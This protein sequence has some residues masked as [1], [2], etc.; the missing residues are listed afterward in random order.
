LPGD[1]RSMRLRWFGRRI[2]RKSGARVRRIAASRSEI[3]SWLVKRLAETLALSEEDV[4]VS[5]PFDRYGLD[6]R[7]AASLSAELEDWLERALPATLVWDY[8]TIASVA[9]FLGAVDGSVSGVGRESCG[10]P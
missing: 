8:P 7:T 4:D 6:S 9:D 2:G 10:E 3:Q 5:I 1:R